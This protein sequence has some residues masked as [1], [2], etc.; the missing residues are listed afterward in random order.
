MRTPLPL[1]VSWLGRCARS[2]PGGS[3]HAVNP[4]V[5]ALELERWRANGIRVGRFVLERGDV[6]LIPPGVAHEVGGAPL[7]ALDS[8]RS[9]FA[10]AA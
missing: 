8:A 3:K 1:C 5:G 9:A 4:P 7:L 2:Q 10:R 6:Y